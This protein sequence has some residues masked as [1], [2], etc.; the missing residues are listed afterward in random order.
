MVL[1]ITQGISPTDIMNLLIPPTAG[2]SYRNVNF[3][4]ATN[5]ASLF[6]DASSVITNATLGFPDSGF[7]LG[8]G[9]GVDL[10]NQDGTEN[11]YNFGTPGDSE[12]TDAY[13]EIL[14][15]FDACTISFEFT[16]NTVATG[17]V[18][19]DYVFSSDEYKEQIIEGAG[20][21]DLFALLLNGVN[22]A[23]VPGSGEGVGVYTVNHENNSEYFVFNDPRPGQSTFP[24]FEPDGFTTGLT[25]QGNIIPGWNTMKIGI[26]DV[27]DPFFDSWLFIK[28]GSF[29]CVPQETGSGSGG[30]AQMSPFQS[31]CTAPF[32]N[33][34]R[35]RRSFCIRPSFQDI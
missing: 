34:F 5:C 4:G 26:T 1:Q 14:P 23:T 35:L 30:K 12:I 32:T 18:N 3:G 27:A 20:Y 28:S 7:V 24:G 19:V 15:S 31:S 2:I 16:C 10:V 21:A 13:G 25:A 17:N 9:L 11:Y 6:S 33:Y 22:I 29:S 8:T